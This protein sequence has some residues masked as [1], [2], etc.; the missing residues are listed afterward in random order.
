MSSFILDGRYIISILSLGIW[1]TRPETSLGDGNLRTDH[2]KDIFIKAYL[3]DQKITEVSSALALV[4]DILSMVSKKV[5]VLR[6][7][8]LPLRH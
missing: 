8:L 5:S 7:T 3:L 2:L 1:E 6:M 4:T